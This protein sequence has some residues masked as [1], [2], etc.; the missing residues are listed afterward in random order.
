MLARHLTKSF[1][2]VIAA[3]VISPI[4]L[5]LHAIP[6]RPG[7]M[8]V[9][10]PEGTEITVTQCGDENFNFYR[11]LDGVLLKR[12][13][14]EFFYA[15]ISPN[16]SLQKVSQAVKAP[17]RI[18]PKQRTRKIS[19]LIQGSTFP[20]KGSPK[21][22]VVLVEYQDIKFNLEDPLDY[23][24]RMLNEEGFSDYRA[25]GSAKDFFTHSSSGQFTPQ[26]DVYGPVT[27]QGKQAY[28]GGN[29]AFDQDFAPQKMVIEACRQ[30]NPDVDFS[31]YDCDN[32]GYIDNVFVF[33][34]GR[35]EASGGS[36]DCVWPHAWEVEV[37]EGGTSY[38]FDNV[39]L[40]RYACSNEW[41]LSSLGYGYRPVGI[42]TFVHEF[43]HIM[44]LPDL[45]STQYV[46]ETFTPGE[47]SA[48]D[49]GPYNNDGCTP[50][51]YS[52]FERS[53]LG[54]MNPPEL[55][56]SGNIAL[57]T[58]DQGDG[59]IISTDD[60]DEYFLIENRQQNG[61][62]TYIPGHGMLVW[63]VDYDSQIWA[64]NQ[65]NNDP[66]HNHV[67]IIEADGIQDEDSR[68]GDCFPGDSAVTA[69][70]GSTVPALVAW[71]G[72]DLDLS[73]L[74]ITEKNG[75]I[76]FRLNGGGS[77]ISPTTALPPKNILAG[78]FTARWYPVDS[79]QGYTLSVYT[80][81][82]TDSI[83]YLP[84]YKNLFVGNVTEYEVDNLTPSSTY[85]YTVKVEDGLYGSI[86]SN[87]IEITTLDP[88]LDYFSPVAFEADS[89]T[90]RSFIASWE[91]MDEAN[92]YFID[93]YTQLPGTPSLDVVDFSN[94]VD[95][96]PDGW[97]TNTGNSY[98]MNSYS[99]EAPPSLRLS[100][101]GHAIVSPLYDKDIVDIEFW[102]RG[103][104]TGKNEKLLLSAWIDGEWKDIC[105]YPITAQ[106]GGELIRQDFSEQPGVR[107]IKLSFYRPEKGSV[108]LDD[109]HL[110]WGI[111][112]I[113]TPVEGYTHKSVGNVSK[114]KIENLQ[115]STTYFYSLTATDGTLVSLPSNVVSV[116]TLDDQSGISTSR[117]E[118]LALTLTGRELT[119]SLPVS[120]YDL[121]G[122]L[123]ASNVRRIRL[124]SAGVYVVCATGMQPRK[125]I[126]Y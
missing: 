112:L 39:H 28:Y 123:I 46:E 21:A 92:E 85:Y 66:K 105:A 1:L 30:L 70:S 55:E 102:I 52:I 22:I 23:F 124:L 101:D 111:P 33:Y 31:Q 36:S 86:A 41:E 78:G 100:S 45:Y 17:D 104:Q 6:A 10:G 38:I 72:V 113:D 121:A 106:T 93:V 11:T 26:F 73:L 97:S 67:D 50:P 9:I 24:S 114:F 79:A 2:L 116:T 57:N 48:M 49:Y 13:G 58:I 84:S 88:T 81:P 108:A 65:V 91:Q 5:H 109:I 16:G 82:D 69:L 43:S 19:G 107:Q 60:P 7:T 87:E 54:Y 90:D 40:N 4:L 29:D 122:R 62:D 103:N 44:G 77:D 64:S 15:E 63:H 120:V 35:G 118:G 83:E 59:Y 80:K 25:T 99:G 125:I 20:V 95:N 126:T 115:P 94:G 71:N 14:D 68:G 37:A 34:A 117:T 51:Q 98:G 12:V 18:P 32:D 89:V 119:A 74:E 96:L 61:W 76:L 47:W 3:T 56:G 110:Q 75:K 8:K 42:G 27:L 53:A